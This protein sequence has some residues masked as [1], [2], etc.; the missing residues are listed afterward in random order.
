[1]G[2]FRGGGPGGSSLRGLP[3][4][5]RP[6]I[7]P[8]LQG[9]V[10]RLPTDLP[11]LPGDTPRRLPVSGAA[12]QALQGSSGRRYDLWRSPPPPSPPDWSRCHQQ[13]TGG[14]SRA[15]PLTNPPTHRQHHPTL[16]ETARIPSLTFL[17]HPSL[18]PSTSNIDRRRA[19]HPA[20][21]P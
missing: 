8:L 17:P 16:S 6:S 12:T 11:A 5:S 1:M 2:F 14:G 7:A 15:E 20:T 19:F 3:R 18:R 4:P 10:A 9:T 13:A 21:T